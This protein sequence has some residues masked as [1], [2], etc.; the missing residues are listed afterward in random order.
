MYLQELFDNLAYG[1]FSHLS[2]GNS[3]IGSIKEAAYPKVVGIVNRALRA[4]YK[5]FI[6]KKKVVLLHMQSGVETYYLRS[7][8]LAAS[9]DA[10]SDSTYLLSKNSVDPFDGDEVIRILD[11]KTSAGL[12]ALLNTLEIETTCLRT[13]S[14]DTFQVI[15]AD[16]LDIL[17][18]KYQA[19]HPKIIIGDDFDPETYEINY[20]GFIEEALMMHIASQLFKGKTSK[21]SEGEGYATNTY[22]YRYEAACQEISILGFAE[23]ADPPESH[24]FEDKGFV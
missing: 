12:P 20:P 5:R 18:I 17:S 6:L 21:A 24:K 8:K 11:V 19:S 4:I 13:L 1:E 15:P 22:H 14:H 23:S 2:I 9:E 3:S 7:S 10:L 16:I